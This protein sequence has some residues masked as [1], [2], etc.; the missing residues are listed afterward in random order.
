MNRRDYEKNYAKFL[1]NSAKIVANHL[2]DTMPNDYINQLN[3]S[4]QISVED[5]QE[6][7]EVKQ[8]K[9]YDKNKIL[10][11]L[12]IGFLVILLLNGGNKN[13]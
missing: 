2:S 3:D 1:I 13:V 12:S 9:S 5:N 8:I 11:W 10:L 4:N 7:V 6:I